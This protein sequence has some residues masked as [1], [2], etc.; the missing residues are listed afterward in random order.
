[1]THCDGPDDRLDD[2]LDGTLSP[3]EARALDAH[4]ATCPGCRESL[5]QRRALARR[6]AELPRTIA[7]PRDR[8]PEVRAAIDAARA[9]R[10][11]RRAWL[12]AA[13][14]VV[15]LGLTGLVGY[16]LG[17]HQVA[18]P[19]VDEARALDAAERD[20]VEAA[21]AFRVVVDE[22]LQTL[23]PDA[24]A[25]ILSGLDELDQAIAELRLALDEDPANIENS[26]SWNALY[27]RKIRFLRSVSRL[28]S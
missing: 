10:W 4:L 13:A 6:V 23:T 7:P 12:A 11:N 16:R 3:D 15:G 20:Y 26:R 9:A 22:R 24:R 1:M 25:R 5:D 14:I 17:S 28:S 27:R 8:W 18:A 21:T 19:A 2:L